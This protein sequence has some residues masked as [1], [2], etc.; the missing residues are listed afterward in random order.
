MR[1]EMRLILLFLFTLNFAW[2]NVYAQKIHHPDVMVYS[3]LDTKWNL[4]MLQELRTLM[5]NLSYDTDVLE[6][7][8]N[9]PI[10]YDE[11]S[12]KDLISE[13]AHVL[14]EKVEAVSGIDI[15]D[16]RPELSVHQVGYKIE[17]LIPSA[18][19]LEKPNGNVTFKVDIVMSG[20]EIFAE[21]VSLTFLLNSRDHN[22]KIPALDLIVS[23]PSLK[24]ANDFPLNF[25]LDIT[26][27]ENKENFNLEFSNE[28]FNKILTA[29]KSHPE[30]F[31]IQYDDILV[32]EVSLNIMGRDLA[33][34][35][36]KLHDAIESNKKSLRSIM[37][38]QLVALIQKGGLV[39][40]LKKLSKKQ[41]SKERWFN[42]ESIDSIASYLKLQ[43]LSVVSDEVLLIKAKGDFCTYNNFVQN[44]KE[45]T[46]SREVQVAKST[47]SESDYRYSQ[48]FAQNKMKKKS[49][50][51][52]A[53][54][55]EDYV[56]KLIATTIE[57]GYWKEVEE[58]MGIKLG[59]KGALVKFNEKGDLASVYVD[60]I[61]DTGL[62]TGVLLNKRHVRFP[63]ILKV[64][65]RIENLPSQTQ[66]SGK[67]DSLS[68]ELSHLVFN[69]FDVDL[70]ENKMRYGIEEY[71]LVSNI[72]EVRKI[73]Q[74]SV[75]KKIK[76]TLFD[77]N[78]PYDR[79]RYGRW[80]GYDLPGLEFPELSN[81]QLDKVITES[82]GHG[83]LLLMLKADDVEVFNKP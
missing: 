29:M 76:N 28:N 12:I 72:P 21:D 70:D 53:S 78:A 32:P 68:G 52:I 60:V 36:Q 8:Y 67:E 81:M 9:E 16:V 14:V 56:N 5:K 25:Q 10:I 4:F 48:S 11:A 54:L 13:D 64:K 40:S 37:L 80:K 20:I 59:D 24:I 50:S 22:K 75:V 34:N 83:R 51:F 46:D 62:L 73:L 33:I 49:M 55:S 2:T 71:D 27:N 6:Y 17:K 82:D 61:Y 15:L 42:T 3:K 74:N 45:C 63:V 18:D 7:N 77:Y 66:D 43:D 57:N 38:K 65:S 23:K 35:S 58:T 41:F 39:K 19:V 44:E 26:I 1:L 79:L 47:L 69:I 31:Q 30:S